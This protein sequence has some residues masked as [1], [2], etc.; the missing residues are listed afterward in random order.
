MANSFM[1][2]LI[3]GFM[4]FGGAGAMGSMGGAGASATGSPTGVTAMSGGGMNVQGTM[5]NINTQTV[6]GPTANPGGSATNA[7]PGAGNPPLANGS[8]TPSGMTMPG[9][10]SK[11]GENIGKTSSALSTTENPYGS[12][13]DIVRT[14]PY[15]E[16]GVGNNSSTAPA[17]MTDQ[18][19]LGKNLMDVG[20][21]MGSDMSRAGSSNFG[22]PGGAYSALFGSSAFGG[23]PIA[24]SP[25]M[26]I[27][28]LTP[29][30]AAAQIAPR[31]QMPMTPAPLPAPMAI[32]MMAPQPQAPVPPAL[33]MSDLRVKTKITKASPELNKFLEGI[34]KNIAAKRGK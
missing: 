22:N 28:Q 12:G 17:G 23:S 29:A 11:G 34:A 16:G 6:T 18:Q 13:G 26:S 21:Q 15:G 5:N 8:G 1:S 7:N 10:P 19:K 32:P 20:K 30:M 14:N 3:N 25:S 9:G 27:P 4:S 24:S 2:G 33:A 31:P